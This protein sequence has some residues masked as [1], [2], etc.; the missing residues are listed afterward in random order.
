VKAGQVLAR[1]DPAD[2]ALQATQAEAQRALAAA[3]LARYRDLKAKNFI[4]AVGARCARNHL[5]GG[6]GAGGAGEEPGELH[7]AGGRSRGRDRPGAGRAGT[8]GGAGQAVFRWRRTANA[9]SRSRYRKAKSAAF[10][11]GQAAEVSFWSA[12]SADKPLARAA[13]AR[14]RRWPIR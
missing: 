1:L 13:C 6:R 9:K 5:Q 3:D 8:G 12:G 11:L 14:C 2:A 7:D 10:K 4:S